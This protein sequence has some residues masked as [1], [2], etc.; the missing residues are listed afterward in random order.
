MDFEI[1]NQPS[2]NLQMIPIYFHVTAIVRN[3]IN[4]AYKR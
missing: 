4:Q 3:V 2:Q 1:N